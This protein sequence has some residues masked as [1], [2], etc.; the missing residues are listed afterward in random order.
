MNRLL[1]CTC[2]AIMLATASGCRDHPV[3]P[4]EVLPPP[5][6]PTAQQLGLVE[7]TLS[8]IGSPEMSASARMLTPGDVVG[9]GPEGEPE[10]SFDL[11][12]L[13]SGSSGGIQIL[14]MSN[15][16]FTEGTRPQGG[17]RY[18]YA[19][20]RV[21]NAA[22]NG[23]PYDGPRTNLT[24]LPVGTNGTIAGTPVSQM[25][26]FDGSTASPAIAQQ[27]VP[28]GAVM[29]D[30]ALEIRSMYPDVLQ[31]FTEEEIAAFTAPPGVT[32]RFP[33]G[34]VTRNPSLSNSRTL[35]ANPKTEE[36]DGLVTFAFRVPLQPSDPGT[37]NGPTKDPFTVSVVFLVVDDSETR[38]TESME[39]QRPEAREA[40]RAR[41]IAIGANPTNV[42][43]GS[44]AMDPTITKYPG[45][46]QIC[47][48]R[49]AGTAAA[50]TT[51][52]TAPGAFSRLTI[53][54]PGEEL[55]ECVPYFR[56][57]KP[58]R[59]ATNVPFDLTV[60]ATDRYGNIKTVVTDT[61]RISATLVGAQ[62][63]SPEPLVA[64]KRVFSITY[65][66]YGNDVCTAATRRVR[67][68]Q[69]IPVAGV[70]RIWTAAAGTIN[71]HTGA[72]WLG[73]AVPM[74]LDSVHIPQAVSHHPQLA[75]SV[76]IG[77]VEV[78][79][80]ATI[81][82]SAFNLTAAGSVATGL[83]GG[84]NATSGRLILA[85]SG[86]TVRGVV[87]RIRVLG[88]YSLDGNITAVSPV[89]VQS[90]RLRSGSFRIRAT[91]Q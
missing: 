49:T 51:R 30:D 40:A 45:Q 85:G 62:E 89:F 59:P 90:G 83:S 61:V 57:G 53:L 31:V 82:L 33:Y 88:T 48:T 41:A 26:R 16:S 47:G 74:Q 39:E 27:V 4:V 5:P 64:G 52:I 54:K 43:D 68:T 50:P 15:G 44:A 17:Q 20:F 87:P 6:P 10:A 29:L 37:S 19:T 78:E 67:S 7:I 25:T 75:Q 71:W 2:M 38:L 70:K 3:E 55:A 24:F 35:P 18:M 28:T 23:T 73:G 12:P 42:L 65:S 21:R 36:F 80:G 58:D 72:N 81:S 66:E 86:Q 91:S 46:R 8:G 60:Y 14:S 56:S 63:P 34:F 77:G 1:A 84:I 9:S 76:E 32:N 79:N 22:A 13:P 69:P 11:A